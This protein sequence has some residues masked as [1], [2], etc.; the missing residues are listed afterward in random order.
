MIVYIENSIY[1]MKNE[2]NESYWTEQRHK[3]KALLIRIIRSVQVIISPF[4]TKPFKRL[5]LF[6]NMLYKHKSEIG[7]IFIVYELSIIRC[8]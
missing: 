1:M 2:D 4:T 6:K 7:R 3:L 8:C 5:W